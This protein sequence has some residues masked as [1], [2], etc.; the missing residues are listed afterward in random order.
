MKLSAEGATAF[1]SNAATAPA[2]NPGIVQGAI[3]ESN[4][5]P[6]LEMTRMI[7]NARQFQLVTQFV[8]AEADRHQSAID[9]LLPPGGA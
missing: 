7:D 6:V 5:Q 8:Q 2:A 9:K 3:E 4:V 1:V